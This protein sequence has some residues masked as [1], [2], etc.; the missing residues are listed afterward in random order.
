MCRKVVIGE[1]VAGSKVVGV[2]SELCGFGGCVSH[3]A[4]QP[5][6]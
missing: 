3:A 6:S 4:S 2:G 5:A 1:E